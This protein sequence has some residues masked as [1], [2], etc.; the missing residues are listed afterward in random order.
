MTT[1]R[2]EVTRNAVFARIVIEV[3]SCSHGRLDFVLPR[4]AFH[5]KDLKGFLHVKNPAPAHSA[6]QKH[7]DRPAN[8]NPGFAFP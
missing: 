7:G 6:R 8:A 4:K 3:R 1:K 2:F 5:P